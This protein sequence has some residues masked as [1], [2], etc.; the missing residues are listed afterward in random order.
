MA[1]QKPV[2]TGNDKDGLEDG[3][4]KEEGTIKIGFIGP[5]TGDISSLGEIAKITAELAV[6]E[7]N[8]AGGVK[9]R[10]IELIA[11]DSQCTP[12][13]GTNAVNKLV[14]IDKVTAIVGGLCSSETAPAAPIA[15]EAGVPM[16]SYCA[17]APGITKVGD[18]IFRVYPSDTFQSVFAAEY[19]YNTLQKKNVAILYVKNDWGQGLHDGFTARFKELGG[20]IVY[21][22][23]FA[24]DARDLRTQI[25][26]VKEANPDLLV[27]YSHPD[28]GV[29]GL[30]QMK[31]LGLTSPILGGDAFDDPKIP[32]EGAEAAEGVMYSVTKLLIPEDFKSKFQAA[33]GKEI[34]ICGPHAY[35]AVKVLAKVMEEAGSD[36]TA[37]RDELAKVKDYQGVSGVITFNTDGDITNNEYEV[38]VI[39]GGKVE[40]A[41]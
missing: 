39:K 32:T 21:D 22:E 12:T 8:D 34:K 11:E 2:L 41:Q 29:P 25:T 20:T 14:N 18:Y 19:A 4:A 40:T 27:F 1:R 26:K 3:E 16:I 17:S 31:E 5:Q 23:S 15:Q 33:T 10:N 7:I 36:K 24:Q 9:G 6:K 30:K 35:D 38:K 37:I 28:A 13:G